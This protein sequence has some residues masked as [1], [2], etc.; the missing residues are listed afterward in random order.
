MEVT[1]PRPAVI[2][3][4]PPRWRT[5]WAPVTATVV[6]AL[7]AAAL[8]LQASWPR[9]LDLHPVSVVP[10][11]NET[12]DAAVDSLARLATDWIEE[13]LAD[14]ALFV[15][16]RRLVG[17]ALGRARTSVTGSIT[18]HGQALHLSAQIRTPQ[19]V[20]WAIGPVATS[21]AF[22]APAI[23]EVRQRV[24]GGIAALRNPSLAS[25]FPLA[26]SPPTL[27]AY[28][29]FLQGLTAD[30]PGQRRD[31]LTHLHRA[32]TLDTTFTLALLQAVQ[33]HRYQIDTAGANS[34]LRALDGLRDRLPP[35][36]RDWLDWLAYRYRDPVRAYDAVRSAATVAPQR[37]LIDFARAARLARRPRETIRLLE[38]VPF[39][40][41]D[42][43]QAPARMALLAESW[44]ELAEHRRELRVAR[45]ARRLD[46]TDLQALSNEVRARAALGQS[47]AV[48]ALLDTAL[49]LP[50]HAFY[51]PGDVMLLAA[52]ELAA[53]QHP[54]PARQAL[55]LAIAWYR[56]RPSHGADTERDRWAL[57]ESLYLAGCWARSEP[58]RLLLL[59]EADSLFRVV[60][61]DPQFALEIQGNLGA[62]AARRGDRRTAEQILAS[63][64]TFMRSTSSP[65][66]EGYF[67]DATIRA[68]LGDAEGALASLRE[69]VGGQGWDLHTQLDFESLM[70][71]AQFREFTRP[72]G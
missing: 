27:E 26:T 68:V 20:S 65:P 59:A 19:G 45:Q 14:V 38:S 64:E 51:T 50:V 57:A 72:K 17:G 9:T 25:W 55:G 43:G 49:A 39:D 71:H 32:A 24:T 69:W 67:A 60:A 62:I 31:A 54:E 53:H 13:S 48:I 8:L 5:N 36:Q 15:E 6:V 44:H 23:D 28:T 18:R 40:A 10:V 12:G 30:R 33:L 11:R 35:L 61:G 3:E 34:I 22:P 66:G 56:S 46:M 41:A 21:L 70:A 1:V 63:L 52:R 16:S 58:Q 7:A 37:F 42:R 2:A 29:E 4:R 47:R